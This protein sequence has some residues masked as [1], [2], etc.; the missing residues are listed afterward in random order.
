MPKP[1]DHVVVVDGK[2]SPRCIVRILNVNIKPL[3]EVD[4]GFASD[5]GGGDRS[6]EWWRSAY[7]RYFSRQGAREGFAV[8]DATV[9][10]LERF[11][12]VWPNELAC[13]R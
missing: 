7:A 10:I 12:V 8:D 1:G 9:V 5:E 3:C 2:N 13:M 4:E 11:E 6:L